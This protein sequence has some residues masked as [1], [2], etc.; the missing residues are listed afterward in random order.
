MEIDHKQTL[1]LELIELICEFCDDKTLL[2]RL[3]GTAKAFWTVLSNDNFWR[4]RS[5]AKKIKYID[6]DARKSCRYHYKSKLMRKIIK[7]NNNT[8]I[9]A[10]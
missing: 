3:P 6:Y 7:S 1:P 10:I 9:F 2:E 4:R 8:T 5:D